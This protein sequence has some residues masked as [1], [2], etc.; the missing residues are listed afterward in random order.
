MLP[1][2][3]TD[4]AGLV[5]SL[6]ARHLFGALRRGPAR[7]RWRCGTGQTQWDMRAEPQEMAN[8][9]GEQNEQ[10]TF[11]CFLVEQ[12]NPCFQFK[13]TSRGSHPFWGSL[14]ERPIWLEIHRVDIVHQ[15]LGLNLEHSNDQASSRPKTSL[16]KGRPR[17]AEPLGMDDTRV[18][19]HATFPTGAFCGFCPSTVQ[20]HTFSM[21]FVTLKIHRLGHGALGFGQIQM[22]IGESKT[23][24]PTGFEGA[25]R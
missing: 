19:K 1:I 8:F 20:R 11:V 13:G 14:S 17:K 5:T 16:R 6:A 24:P 10:P 9:S 22:N 23:D 4:V 21:H 18:L 7:P 25:R 15:L 3:T 2:W 12:G